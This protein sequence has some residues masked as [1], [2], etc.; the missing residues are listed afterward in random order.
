MTTEADAIDEVNEIIA[1]CELGSTPELVKRLRYLLLSPP[2]RRR[3]GQSA[4]AVDLKI[5]RLTDPT[6]AGGLRVF[7]HW[8]DFTGWI[9]PE[10]TAP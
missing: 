7:D 8:S 3:I 4:T 1:K 2:L 5:R 9:K 10:G 6:T